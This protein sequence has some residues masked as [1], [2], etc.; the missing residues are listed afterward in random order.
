MIFNGYRLH[1]KQNIPHS[2]RNQTA[3]FRVQRSYHT[4]LYVQSTSFLSYCLFA[5]RSTKASLSI[6]LFFIDKELRAKQAVRNV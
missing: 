2:L 4:H 5:S 3:H 1:S 6:V